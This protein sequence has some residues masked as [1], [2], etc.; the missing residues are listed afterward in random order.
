MARDTS[1]DIT[2]ENMRARLSD[3]SKGTASSLKSAVSPKSSPGEL[4]LDDAEEILGAIYELMVKNREQMVKNREDERTLNKKKKEQDDTQHKEILKALTVRR[5]PG[6]KKKTKEVKKEEPKKPAEKTPEKKPTETKGT[7]KAAQEAKDKAAQK[8]K[9]E[10]EEKAKLEAKKKAEQEAKDKAAEK[11]KQDAADKA[12]KDA[13]DK[14]KKDAADK[15]KEK[16]RTAEPVKEKLQKPPEPVKPPPAPPVSGATAAKVVG[17]VAL[18]T[19]ASASM[20]A[21]PLAENIVSHESKVSSPKN[22]QKTKWKDNSEYNAYNKG[23]IKNKDKTTIVPADFDKNGESIIDFSKM[24]IEEYLRRGSLKSGD[25]DKILAI[26]RYQIIPDTMKEIVDKLKIDP[27]TTFLNKETQDYLFMAGLIGKK[28]PLVK[29]YIDGD[30]NVT[31][32]QAIMELAQEFASIGV[33]YD[34]KYKGKEIKKGQSFYS[35][36][37]KSGSALNPPE[38]V[39]KALDAQRNLNLKEKQKALAVPSSPNTGNQT[40][41]VSLENQNLRDQ[42]VRDKAALNVV[43]QTTNVQ[44]NSQSSVTQQ[45]VDDRPPLLRK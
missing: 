37:T 25:P 20:A 14:A 26:G 15:A 31:R 35:Q 23:T 12:K 8:A 43:N 28:R 34:T 19:A 13:A 10:A 30:P 44:Q 11:A 33:P 3:K 4:K 40:N 38:D 7:D 32:D 39:G 29:K 42:A 27:K 17:G 45:K 36:N 21:G 41:Q 16:N 22:G 1:K 9:Q 24:S 2:H 6:R 5:K 18:A